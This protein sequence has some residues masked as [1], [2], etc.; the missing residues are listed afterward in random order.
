M[1]PIL[2][3]EI[4]PKISGFFEK[5][6]VIVVVIIFLNCGSDINGKYLDVVSLCLL[7]VFV[8]FLEEKFEDAERDNQKPLFV[9]GQTI[10]LRKKRDKQANDG[11]QN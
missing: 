8:C 10:Q 3:I 1:L 5:D 7:N 4:L 11:R 6:W 9:E 2:N